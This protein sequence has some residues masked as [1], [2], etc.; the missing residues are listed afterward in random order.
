MGRPRLGRDAARRARPARAPLLGAPAADADRRAAARSSSTAPGR[1]VTAESD[2]APRAAR[3]LAETLGLR[4]VRARRRPARALPRRRG[5]RVEL[6]RHALPRCVAALRRGGRAAGGARPADGADDRERLRADRPDR[7]RRLGDGRAAPRGARAASGLEHALRRARGGDARVIVAR[8]IAE[9]DAAARHG[10]VGLV[11]TMGAL[12]AGHAR[13]ASRR[14]APSATSSS[15][16][17]SS[18]RRSSPTAA[19]SPR[20]RATSTRDAAIAEA[21]GVDVLFAPRRDEMYPPGFATWVEPE[22]AAEGLECDAPPRPLPRRRD[23]LPEALQHRPPAARVV[24]AQGRAAGR[25]AEAARARPERR[26]RDPRRRHGAR[27]RRPRALVAQRA[28]LAR[29]AR[30]RRCAIPRALATRDRAQ[31]RAVLATPASSPTTSRSPTSTAPPS[32]SPHASA[33]P[34]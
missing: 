11:P 29:G 33:R 34:A 28:P 4:A 9:L 17:S 19:I 20:T 16:A 5:D 1:A 10:V 21:A 13:A 31:A 26:R 8:S 3:W 15:R 23:G 14:R 6:P 18:T 24:R 12:H 27:R 2:E 25:R 30:R 22:G 32:R 7:A